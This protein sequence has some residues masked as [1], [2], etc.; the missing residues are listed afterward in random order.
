MA[1]EGKSI[2]KFIKL[3][4]QGS[5]DLNKFQGCNS[6][7][8]DIGSIN[9]VVAADPEGT[10]LTANALDSFS[11]PINNRSSE[12]TIFDGGAEIFFKKRIKLSILLT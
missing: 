11:F 2:F 4:F 8:K 10:S 7:L 5:E 12:S 3:Y 6:T 9:T 1:E